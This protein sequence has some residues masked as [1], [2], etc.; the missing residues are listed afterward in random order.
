MEQNKQLIQDRINELEINIAGGKQTGKTYKAINNIIDELFTKPL[1]SQIYLVD[2]PKDPD[3]IKDFAN[4]FAARMRHD[5]P[6]TYF[7]ISYPAPGTAI[8]VRT[9]ETYQELTKKRLEQWKKKL[10]EMN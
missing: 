8:V 4:L 1:G 5:F 6:D 10:E 7:K 2:N 3:R 9:S